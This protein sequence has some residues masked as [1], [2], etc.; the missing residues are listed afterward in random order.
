MGRSDHG[1][2]Y[3]ALRRTTRS[4]I[5]VANYWHRYGRCRIR[6]GRLAPQTPILFLCPDSNL[7]GQ[8]ADYPIEIQSLKILLPFPRLETCGCPFSPVSGLANGVRSASA[9]TPIFLFSCS[10]RL[11]S[12]V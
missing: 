12:F 7:T 5:G 2:T 11:I 10:L 1:E 6:S 4:S 9:D 3:D 8:T